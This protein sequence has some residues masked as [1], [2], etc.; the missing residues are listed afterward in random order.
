MNV[1]LEYALVCF[2]PASLILLLI[3]LPKLVRP[4]LQRRMTPHLTH[5]PIEQLVGDLRRLS[6][7]QDR[8]RRGEVPA[9][10]RRLTAI[11]LAY[12]DVLLDCCVVLE[13]P[14]SGTPPLTHDQRL[15]IE[16]ALLE[17]GLRW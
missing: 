9:R 3:H 12:D 11:D 16:A 2:L 5:P 13:L 1:W 7:E 10:R 8:V 4:F 14:H 15:A 6:V 17:A